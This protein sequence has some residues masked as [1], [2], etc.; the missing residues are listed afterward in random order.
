MLANQK[1]CV[2]SL[3]T[4]QSIQFMDPQPSSTFDTAASAIVTRDT[5]AQL[6]M[7]PRIA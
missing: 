6:E 3:A 4:R 7:T 2:S 5:G 1:R